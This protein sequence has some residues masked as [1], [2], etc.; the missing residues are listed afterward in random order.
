MADQWCVQIMGYSNRYVGAGFEYSCTI[1]RLQ[2][3]LAMMPTS[4]LCL[5]GVKDAAAGAGPHLEKLFSPG[6]TV[7]LET[8]ERT[9]FSC[10]LIRF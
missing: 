1:L 6:C 8:P 9:R 7:I 4:L 10:L 3:A 5:S 2:A